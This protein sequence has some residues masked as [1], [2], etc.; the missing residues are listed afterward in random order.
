MYPWF[1]CYSQIFT[2]RGVWLMSEQITADLVAEELSQAILLFLN[3]LKQ[4]ESLPMIQ[5]TLPFD[6][7]ICQRRRCVTSNQQSP[8]LFSH[9]PRWNSQY[10]YRS[11]CEG[12][13]FGSGR[14]HR[15]ECWIISTRFPNHIKFLV[16]VL[17]N[18]CYALC[19]FDSSKDSNRVIVSV[20]FCI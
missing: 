6:E 11:L 20:I 17:D 7:S 1:N 3:Y 18:R 14:V 8:R 5:S 16:C 9:S 4:S 19:E 12:Q 10:P 2:N 15:I 13:T